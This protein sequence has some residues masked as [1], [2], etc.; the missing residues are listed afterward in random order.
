MASA[1]FLLHNFKCGGDVMNDIN[2]YP[3]SSRRSISKLSSMLSTDYQTAYAMMLLTAA[4]MDLHPN[5]SKVIDMILAD[6]HVEVE[7]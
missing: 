1:L 5:D 3:V 4:L 6:C 2:T 7:A